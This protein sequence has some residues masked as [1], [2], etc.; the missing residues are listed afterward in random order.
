ML[1]ERI[2]GSFADEAS[3][4]AAVRRA[5]DHG[6]TVEDVF[7]PYPI[8]GLEDAMGLARTRL[9]WVTLAGGLAGI[10]SAIALQ[11]WT[12]VVDWPLNVGGKPANSALAFVPIT[13]ELTVLLAGLSSAAAFLWRSRLYPAAPIRL[14]APGATNDT[15]VLALDAAG[16]HGDSV[17]Q[18]LIDTGAH[19]VHVDGGQQ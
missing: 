12:S 4:L 8:H 2:L 18:L 10:V 16:S 7:A 1:K 19:H 17:R 13:F 14:A 5:R 11:V 9:P 6:L 15:F 3:L